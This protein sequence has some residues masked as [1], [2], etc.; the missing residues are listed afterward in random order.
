M[1]DPWEDHR[2]F[3]AVDLRQIAAAEAS[4]AW[5]VALLGYQQL[6]SGHPGQHRLLVNA[7]R[8]CWYLD[9][10]L[11]ACRYYRQALVLAPGDAMPWLGLANA[12]RDLNKF[13]AADRCY[14]RSRELAPDPTTAWNHSQ[15]LIGLERYPQAYALAEQRLQ[16]P[17]LHPYRTA[18]SLAGFHAA[19]AIHLWSE[20]G[21]GDSLQYL[22]WAVVLSETGVPVVLELDPALVSLVRE[23]FSWLPRAF[24]VQPQRPVPDA[25]QAHAVQASLLTLPHACGGAPL[26]SLFQPAGRDGFWQGY[27]RSQ[28]WPLSLPGRRPRVGLVWAAGRKLDDPF[29]TREYGK[30][31]LPASFLGALIQG[32][33]ALGADLVDLQFGPDRHRAQPWLNVFAERLPDEA[34][35]A[36]TA[37]WIRGLDLLISVDTAA[38]HL[39]GALGHPCW[40]L[41][42]YSADPR[43]LRQRDDSPW[44]PSLRLFR[45]PATDHWGAAIHQLLTAFR[46]WRRTAA[47]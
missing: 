28:A 47:G 37:R 15:V 32:L 12:L 34:D 11:Q 30:R 43:W 33:D 17:Q 8:A 31:S 40:L 20:Q 1:H 41:L 16:L 36:E 39:A 35:F 3:P 5:E 13:E 26:S 4:G 45:Q 7:G 10:P 21:Y 46:G 22:R 44:Y 9:R 27:L 24:S 2:S 42:P 14:L 23:G 18:G 29:T 38:A 25:L 19:S 6:L